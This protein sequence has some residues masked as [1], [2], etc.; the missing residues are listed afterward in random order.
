MSQDT[1]DIKLL[2]RGTLKEFQ[3]ME[4]ISLVITKL[5]PIVLSYFHR[6]LGDK[7]VIPI[8]KEIGF[9]LANDF[10]ANYTKRQK[11]FQGYIKYFFKKFF[12]NKVTIEQMNENLFYVTD[13]NCILCSDTIL[14]GIPFHY[15]I[16]IGGCIEQ[17]LTVLAEQDKI[18]KFRYTAE[19][20]SSRGLGNQFCI[21]TI[22]L[23]EY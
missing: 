8:L 1:Q 15:C 3:K 11:T 12:G 2:R 14:E 10:L 19:T 17:L 6:K 5:Y 23:E 18:P 16:P 20:A 7:K 13:K 9:D 21:Y 22:R 4:M